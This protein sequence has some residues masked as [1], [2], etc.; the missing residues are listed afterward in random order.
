MASG[1]YC[2]FCQH[3]WK[4]RREYDRHIGCCEYF[5][6]QRRNPQPEMDEHG[7]R[8]PTAREL[9][10]YV[11]DLTVR[12]EKTE[13]EVVRLRSLMNTRQKKA[14]LEWLNQPGQLPVIT[15]EE[16]WNECRATDADVQHT[17]SRD[18]TD[19]IKHCI[20]TRLDSSVGS[21]LPIRSF[22][23][24]PNTFYVYSR[25]TGNRDG[26][27]ATLPAWRI[28][29][30]EQL[31]RM[32]LHIS[33]SILREFL[34]W[35]KTNLQIGSAEQDEKTMDKTVALMMKING[36][37]IA[38]DKRLVEIKRWLYPKLEENLRVM[39]SCE[40]E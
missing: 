5:Y 1:T 12:L 29:S 25:D 28:M 15:F 2:K 16:W 37:G 3:T 27:A 11:Q 34:V 36:N 30:N 31:E 20:E 26:N 10:R 6:Y 8:I 7:T 39:A 33:Q 14:I 35:Q 24:K 9:F 18:L 17:I 21:K 32:A 38:I 23:Q 4:I 19:G 13:K 22:T 40:F